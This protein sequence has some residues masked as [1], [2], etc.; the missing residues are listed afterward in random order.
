MKK[1]F[2]AVKA[3]FRTLSEDGKD[4]KRKEVCLIDAVTFSEAETRAFEM[5]KEMR[6]VHIISIARVIYDEFLRYKDDESW[7]LVKVVFTNITRKGRKKSSVRKHILQASSIDEA[8]DRLSEF[9]K[10]S[11][12]DYKISSISKTDYADVSIYNEQKEENEAK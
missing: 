9:L 12:T 4:V 7:Y 2:F 10:G 3:S 11:L 1:D 6:D 5:M 8:N